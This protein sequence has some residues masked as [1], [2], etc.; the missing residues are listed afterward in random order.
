MIIEIEI[1]E[2]NI[3]LSLKNKENIIAETIFPNERSLEMKIIPA[4]D[5]MLE[6]SQIRASDVEKVLVHSD[7]SDSFTTTRIAR[8]FANGW[9]WGSKYGGSGIK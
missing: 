7:Q 5:K 8:S 9:N 6:R 1:K 3:K 2:K 4:V